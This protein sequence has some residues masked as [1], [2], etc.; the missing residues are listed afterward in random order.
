[1]D[2]EESSA[3]RP[4][5]RIVV[6]DD[7]PVYRFALREILKQPSDLEVVGEAADGHEA[8]RLCRLLRPD[9]MIMDVK[10]PGMSGIE[11]NR[12]IKE[13][14]PLIIV[15]MLTGSEDPDHL[16]GALKAGAAGYLLKGASAPEIVEATRKVLLGASPL[17]QE[18]AMRLLMCLMEEAPKDA[19][20]KEQMLP[21]ILSP[22]EGE[23][24]RLMAGAGNEPTDR[25]RTLHQRKHRQGACPQR[26]HK[27]WGL[28]PHPGDR[29][30]HRT[31]MGPDRQEGEREKPTIGSASSGQP[32]E[33]I[34]LGP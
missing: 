11:A 10:M 21:E 12:K 16:S 15:L 3:G 2:K 7:D 20:P 27:A 9:L 18:V 30:G 8:I 19:L 23:V 24:L 33:V 6:V 14:S 13:E 22:R 29:Q 17:N 5:S 4:P 34:A 25:L 26:H 32:M 31:G 1:M 28:R